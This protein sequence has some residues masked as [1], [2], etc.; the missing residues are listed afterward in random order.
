MKTI[1]AGPRDFFPTESQ[2]IKALV[3]AE[4]Y[5]VIVDELVCGMAKGVDECAY[6]WFGICKP[7]VKRHEF[8]A[9]WKRYGNSAGAIRNGRMADFADALIAIGAPDVETKGSGTQNMIKTML[10][11]QKPLVVFNR[12]LKLILAFEPQPKLI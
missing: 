10:S 3:M 4:T 1:I 9:N 5:G 7:E 12:E 11:L 6:D 2:I 8:P